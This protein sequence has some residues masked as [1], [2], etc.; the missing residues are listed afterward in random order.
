MKMGNEEIFEVMFEDSLYK[1]VLAED[2]EEQKTLAGKW[3]EQW[4]NEKKL[5]VC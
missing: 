1:V 2:Y 3:I 5:V 4:K